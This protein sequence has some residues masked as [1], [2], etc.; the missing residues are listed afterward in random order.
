MYIFNIQVTKL[1][2]TIHQ[3]DQL[4]MVRWV[5]GNIGICSLGHWVGNEHQAQTYNL[6]TV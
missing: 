5:I 4:I 3:C 6:N 1:T 2:V